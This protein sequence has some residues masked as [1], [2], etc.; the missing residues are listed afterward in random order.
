MENMT[1]WEEPDNLHRTGVT[2]T[3]M[4][5]G[6]VRGLRLSGLRLALILVDPPVS[7]CK[8]TFAR[9]HVGTENFL[10]SKFEPQPYQGGYVGF[11]PWSQVS[12]HCLGVH[13]P[14]APAWKST[15]EDLCFYLQDFGKSGLPITSDILCCAKKK[16]ILSHYMYLI[17]YTKRLLN[18][19][20]YR[21]EKAGK[22]EEK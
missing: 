1:V 2:K 7:S 3:Q 22:N 16:L 17:E 13:G 21:C 18:F 5:D 6:K 20:E 4:A 19:K 9:S 8:Q 15:L 11:R 14:D 10:D 12:K